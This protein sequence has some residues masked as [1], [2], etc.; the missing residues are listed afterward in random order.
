MG[1]EPD[2]TAAST[3][4]S[5]L[6]PHNANLHVR[7]PHSA[8]PSAARDAFHAADPSTLDVPRI[9]LTLRSPGALGLPGIE[10]KAHDKRVRLACRYVGYGGPEIGS[11]RSR[12]LYEMLL[13][14]PQ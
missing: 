13:R 1:L 5:D 4:A 6:P 12:S 11:W 2:H 7:G 8:F 14:P 10:Q 9:W 3:I